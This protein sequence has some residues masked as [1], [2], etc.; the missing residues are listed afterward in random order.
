[1][2]IIISTDATEPINVVVD[3]VPLK[4]MGTYKNVAKMAAYLRSDLVTF[5]TGAGIIMDG[6]IVVMLV[7]NF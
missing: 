5:I 3:K 1:M 7:M 4:Q 6:G 2:I